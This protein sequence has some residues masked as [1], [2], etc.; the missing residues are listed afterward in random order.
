MKTLISLVYAFRKIRASFLFRLRLDL[1]QFN[2]NL[3]NE[4]QL[5]SPKLL[6]LTQ[7]NNFYKQSYCSFAKRS[8]KSYSNLVLLQSMQYCLTNLRIMREKIKHLNLTNIVN[9]KKLSLMQV[10]LIFKII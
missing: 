8:L 4:S 6:S 10:S 2:I 9:K 5:E 3:R 7:R 1:V